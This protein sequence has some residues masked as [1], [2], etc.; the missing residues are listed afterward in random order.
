MNFTNDRRKGGTSV[1]ASDIQER[2]A[3]VKA[4]KHEPIWNTHD[5]LD[6][7]IGCLDAV[8]IKEPTPYS[9]RTPPMVGEGERSLERGVQK[10]RIKGGKSRDSFQVVGRHVFWQTLE[11]N[12]DAGLMFNTTRYGAE[13]PASHT[14]D[15]THKRGHR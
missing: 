2:G 15:S 6:A 7:A 3:E 1:E 11:A 4:G 9:L 12:P 10:T 5:T 8:L 13:L 14:A